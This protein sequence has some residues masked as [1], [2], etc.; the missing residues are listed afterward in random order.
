MEQGFG[1]GYRNQRYGWFVRWQT[2]SEQHATV[3]RFGAALT[4]ALVTGA[5][6][7]ITLRTPL[8]PVPF[9]MQVFGIALTGGL[10]GRKWGTISALLYVGVGVA[11]LPIFAG[12]VASF[13]GWEFL[14][15]GV[16]T[17]GLSSWY[18]AGFV[19]QA[20]IIGAIVES[21]AEH[22]NL[23][24][25]AFAPLAI[26]G[27]LLFAL[28]DV[29]YLS[30]Y[31]A[32]YGGSDFPNVWFALLS[33]GILAVVASFAWLASTRKARRERIEL[34]FGNVVG[35]LALYAIGA[36]GLYIVW[37]TTLGPIGLDATL[38]Y[39]VLPFISVDLAKILLA[40]GLLTLVR[41]THEEVRRRSAEATSANV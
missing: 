1:Q 31:G 22:R 18:L 16:F 25:L 3:A 40:I 15:F 11:G 39:A 37:R 35:L 2:W 26:S 4:M 12:E 41:P 6:A 23:K 30:D 19:A 34:F 38:A 7:Q 9:T 33:L 17:T 14:R 21:K 5:L 27:L 32:L 20:Y 13:D 29:Y 36:A 28:L 10:L 24:L 8:T